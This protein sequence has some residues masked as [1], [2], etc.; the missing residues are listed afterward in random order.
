[1][2]YFNYSLKKHNTFGLECIADQ[3]I[4]V[5]SEDEAVGLFKKNELQK[6]PFLIIGG[7]S[8][9]LFTGDFKG[10]IIYP[11]IAGISV[12]QESRD[13]VIVSAGA[14]IVW[15]DF[16]AWCVER[17]FGGAENL[18]LIPGNCGAVPVQNI[19]AYGIEVKDII[20]RVRGISTEDGSVRE[21]DN[22][23]CRFGYRMSIFKSELKGRYLVTRIFFRLAVKP[24]FNLS[25]GSLREE[26]ATLGEINLRN[27]RQAVIKIRQSKLPDPKDTGNAGSFFKNPVVTEALAGKLLQEY[28]GM[29]VYADPSGGKKLAAGWLIEKSGWKGRS[30]GQAAVHDKQALVLVNLG[31][32]TGKEIYQL[33]E[34]VRRSVC[35]KFG[36]NLEREVEIVGSI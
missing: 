34:E 15:D 17:G 7:G 4:T 11:G 1:M 24:D 25:Y 21:F 2:L 3:F 29:P 32:A 22:D 27:I 19:G 12:E 5:K 20:S 10:T 31:G 26:A 8:N 35:D 14:G 16:V 28:P 36:V 30:I 13:N 18:S 33:S 6:E 9:I 23:E